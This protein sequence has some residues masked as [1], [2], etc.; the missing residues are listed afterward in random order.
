MKRASAKATKSISHA[1]S[2]K[3]VTV[4]ITSGNHSSTGKVTVKTK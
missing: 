1:G 3:T 2:V 4:R